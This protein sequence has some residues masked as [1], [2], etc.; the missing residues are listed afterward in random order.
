MSE[1]AKHRPKPPRRRSVWTVL[2]GE[3]TGAPDHDGNRIRIP[4]QSISFTSRKRARRLA[5]NIQG[6]RVVYTKQ[7]SGSFW[8]AKRLVI[9]FLVVVLLVAIFTR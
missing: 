5:A 3:A 6:A 1:H 2:T 7:R 8:T 4:A 9:A